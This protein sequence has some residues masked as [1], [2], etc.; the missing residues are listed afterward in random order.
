VY[1]PE[2]ISTFETYESH[3]LPLLAEHGGVLQQRLRSGDGLVEIDVVCFPSA[4]AFARFREDP[5]R[6]QHA[7]EL[8]ASGALIELLQLEDVIEP[9]IRKTARPAPSRR[10]EILDVLP[11]GGP[12]L[13]PDYEPKELIST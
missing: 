6:A 1:P 3:V 11:S 8:E 13:Q 12:P 4:P 2:G 7:P 10:C 5:R 9:G